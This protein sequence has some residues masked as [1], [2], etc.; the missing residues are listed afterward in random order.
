MHKTEACSL[1]NLRFTHCKWEPNSAFKTTNP[2]FVSQRFISDFDKWNDI[3][4]VQ[5]KNSLCS[6]SDNNNVSCTIDMLGPI[7]PGENAIFS[8]AL[9][10]DE[11]Y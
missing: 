3:V 7:Y 10:D 9:T 11:Q 8:L 1:S 2:L 4:N 5:T 6:C